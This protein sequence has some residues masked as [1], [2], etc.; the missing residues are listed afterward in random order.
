MTTHDK[1]RRTGQAAASP[2]SA[3]R[4]GLL[5]A[6]A[7]MSNIT[8]PLGLNII[9][10]FKPFPATHIHDQ[11]HVRCLVLDDG[12]TRL[13][14]VVC[15][16]LGISCALSTAA[17]HLI[18][19]RTGLPPEH[20]LISAV[21]THSAVSALGEDRFAL[22]PPLDEYQHFVCCRI[23]DAVACAVNNLRPAQIAF[24]T[25]SA[26]EHLFNRRWFL[27]AGTLS[28][29]PFGKIDSVQMNPPPGSPNLLKP[30][31]PTDPEISFISV[32]EPAGS[33]IAVFTVYGLHYV[34]GNERGHVSADYYGVYARE[35]TRRLRATRRD[36]PFVAIMA[37]GA[38]GDVNNISFLHPRK[39]VKPYARMNA[40]AADMAAKVHAAMGRLQYRDKVTLAACYRTPAINSRPISKDELRWADQTL[41]AAEKS[42][43]PEKISLPLIYARRMLALSKY[44][45][46]IPVP[47]QVFRIGGVCLG[48][49]PCEVFCEIGLE[50][51]KRSPVRPAVMIGLA[52]GYLGYLPTPRQHDLGGYETWPGSNRLERRASEKMLATLLEMAAEL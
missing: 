46:H 37:N 23:A 44:P 9:G 1:T 47:L 39:P 28:P 12:Q 43:A 32:R 15:D 51:K 14:L 36:P 24:G 2:V 4:G 21:H 48:A 31:G 7:A 25:A 5:L 29:N 49:M 3:A 19:E 8:P 16:V 30:A 6:G 45:R 42:P 38:S 22:N 35:L 11:L 41:A 27:K 17:R 18:R 33:L 26:P 13:A 10:G 20:V 50:F 40:V 52:H 34:G